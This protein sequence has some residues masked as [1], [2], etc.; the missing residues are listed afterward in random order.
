[1]RSNRVLALFAIVICWASVGK[2]AEP[3]LSLFQVR[4]DS[5]VESIGVGLAPTPSI[6]SQIPD[7]FIP[8]GANDPVTPIVVRTARCNLSILGHVRE[9]RKIV[10]I[11]AVIVPPDGTGDINNYCIYY[12]T[13]DLVLALALN[14]SGVKAQYV[15]VLQYNVGVDGDFSVRV[16]IP[17]NPRLAI[18][19]SVVPSNVPVGAFVANWWQSGYLGSVKMTTT[20]PAIKIGGADLQLTTPSNSSLASLLGTSEVGFP[21]LQQ[22]NG[23]DAATMNVAIGP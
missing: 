9:R 12:Y 23:F 8:V 3:L 19:G 21:I 22:F 18:R 11:G 17:A 4:F 6:Q 14:L 7:G 10:Q 15:P 20:V 2:T 16:P 1:M 5:C 13:D